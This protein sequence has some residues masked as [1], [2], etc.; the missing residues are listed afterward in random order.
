MHPPNRF[1]YDVNS[2]T[3]IW[4]HALQEWLAPDEFTPPAHSE[5][6]SSVAANVATLD[7]NDELEWELTSYDKFTVSGED[8]LVYG[9][10]YWPVTMIITGQW[11]T[12]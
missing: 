3:V 4:Y 2:K 7:I 10:S 5:S 11:K 6:T 1:Y 12:C 9:F 8:C